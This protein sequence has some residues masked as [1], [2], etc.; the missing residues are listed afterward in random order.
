MNDYNINDLVNHID[1]EKDS[2]SYIKGEI[3]LTN[4]EVSI[5][6]SLG[7]NYK[8]YKSMI[9][10]VNKLEEYI[11]DDSEIEEIVKDMSDRNYYLNINK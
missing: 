11:D 4:R 3:V 7:I 8:T 10:L 5:L 2:I 1:F 9:S 6:N